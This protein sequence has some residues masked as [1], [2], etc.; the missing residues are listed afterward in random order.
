[1]AQCV[2][3][4]GCRWPAILLHWRTFSHHSPCPQTQSVCIGITNIIQSL[5]I[6]IAC[7]RLVLICALQAAIL[8]AED[9]QILG[10][11]KLCRSRDSVLL[12]RSA[13]NVQALFTDKPRFWL[14]KPVQ[15]FRDLCTTLSNQCD[16]PKEHSLFIDLKTINWHHQS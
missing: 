10:V 5:P 7:N 8:E 4:W 14:K 16:K 2:Q 13:L 9:G 1:M 12:I 15:K 11:Q 3:W 6:G